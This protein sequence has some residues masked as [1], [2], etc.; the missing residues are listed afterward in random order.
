MKIRTAMIAPALSVMAATG[1]GA[2]ASTVLEEITVLRPDDIESGDNFGFS[3]AIGDGLIL[4]GATGDDDNGE[5]SGSVYVFDA[6]TGQQL[7]KLLPSDGAAGD[8]FGGSVSIDQ[9]L[10]IIG[11]TSDDDNGSNAGAVYLFDVM[12]GQ[13][14][15]KLL[16][17]DGEGGDIFGARVSISGGVILVGAPGADDHGLNSG[18]AYVFD[19]ATGQQLWKILPY[20]G[21]ALSSF[22]YSVALRD[23]IA[24]I[25]APTS[26]SEQAYVFRATTAKPLGEL[27]PEGDPGRAFGYSVALSGD[28]LSVVSAHEENPGSVYI[29]DTAACE[30]LARLALEDPRPSDEF[31]FPATI[32]NGRV[33]VYTRKS[34]TSQ[35]LARSVLVYDAM[36]SRI[37]TRLRPSDGNDDS[38]GRSIAA[39]GDLVVVS[40]PFSDGPGEI[41]NDDRGSVYVFDL[42]TCEL[43]SDITGDRVV[44]T[45][46][47]GRLI[48]RI[49]ELGGIADFNNDGIVDTADLGMLL[50][51]FG[52]ACP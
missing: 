13:Q 11:A 30:R 27:L 39:E 41:F 29:Y 32:D 37:L 16:P 42:S 17:D 12:T 7:R 23:D 33:F 3:I 22:G 50:A 45:S 48:R 51:E 34:G 52:C 28:G 47:L 5:N 36:T 15:R 9:G 35:E 20:D 24:V 31:G 44:D 2:T 43:A 14:L 19:A 40:A 26:A 18:S 8:K 1:V 38:F 21:Q 25:G 6:A 4:V 46:D 10:A 49:G